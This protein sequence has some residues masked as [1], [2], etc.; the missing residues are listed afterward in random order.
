[1]EAK[2]IPSSTSF[3]VLSLLFT[4]LLCISSSNV[5]T[6]SA[7]ITTTTTPSI[8]YT[9][10]LKT[11]CN[12]TTY[13]QLCLKSLSSYTST[14]K[15]NELKLCSTA[16]TVALKASSN[17]SKL[18]KSLSK[19]RGLSKTEAAIIR[20]CIEE[21]GNS[22]DEIKQSV[23]VLRSLTGSDRELQIDNLK[24]WVS[25]AITDQTTCT[26]GF[27]GNNVNYAV[28]RAIT[29]SIVNVARLTSNALTFINNLSY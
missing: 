23:K 25:G 3:N 16:L 12:S 18:V 22:I 29:K 5:Q 26:D 15:T 28:K 24:T 8:T 13:P 9:N 14:I 21:I 11:A 1:M 20:D 19:I 10:Y 2:I 17:T 6:S 4:F 27:D 7:A